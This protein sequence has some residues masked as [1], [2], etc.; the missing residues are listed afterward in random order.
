MKDVYETPRLEIIEFEAE[1]VITTSG[2]LE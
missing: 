1:D 2:V